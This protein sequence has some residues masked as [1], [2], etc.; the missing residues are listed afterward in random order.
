VTLAVLDWAALIVG[1]GALATAIGGIITAWSA[2]K[3]A[4]VE[5]EDA[6]EARVVSARKATADARAEADLCAEELHR[7]RMAHP[8]GLGE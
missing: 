4:R 5:G 2:L 7:W 6:A 1:I 3:R 8:E